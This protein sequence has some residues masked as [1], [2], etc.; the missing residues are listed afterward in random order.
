MKPDQWKRIVEVFHRAAA[1]DRTDRARFLDGACA[2]DAEFRRRVERMLEHDRPTAG[3][4]EHAAAPGASPIDPLLGAMIGPYRVIERISAGGMG[5]VY[6]AR[7]GDD[8]AGP[9]V[10][11]KVV[12]WDMDPAR[13]VRRFE[14]ERGVLASL[15]HPN[16]A[17]L[18]DGGATADGLPYL[19][20][21]HIDGQP[22]DRYCDGRRLAIRQRLAIFAVVCRAV[23][24]AHQRLVVHRDLKP[25]NILVTP[26]GVPKILDFGIAKVLDADGAGPADATVTT[27][28]AL[29]PAYASPEQLRGEPV[30]TAADVYS[31]GVMLHGLVAGD[32]NRGVR[33]DVRNIIMMALREEPSRRYGSA[34][35]FAD[36]I[37]RCLSGFPVA[38]RPDTLRYR[39]GRFIRR[40]PFATA[41]AAAAVLAIIGGALAVGAAARTARRQRDEADGAR[42]TA[43]R[44][45]EYA[46]VEAQSATEL[47]RFVVG[48]FLLRE[49]SD[50]EVKGV[51]ESARHLV[52]E[53]SRVRR[54]F[55]DQP[56]LQANLLDALGHVYLGLNRFDEARRAIGDAARLRSTAFGP[57]SREAALSFNS[58]GE[59]HHARGEYQDA[60]ACFG[61]ALSIGR[62][63]GAHADIAIAANNLGATLRA[64][65]RLDEA[66]ALHREALALRRT[67]LGD[68]DPVVAE[69][70]NN[71]ASV[72]LDRG[73]QAGAEAA[74]AES[75]EVRRRV[76][77][78]DH[79]LSVQ[80]LN[81]LAVTLHR[82]GNLDRAE[83]LYRDAIGLYRAIPDGD[84]SALART[85]SN[86]ARILIARH[87]LD[88]AAAVLEEALDIQRRVLGPEH[89]GVANVLTGLAQVRQLQGDPAAARPLLADGLRLRRAG[90]PPDHPVIAETLANYGAL[91]L[92]LRDLPGAEQALREALAL[93]D[94]GPATWRLGASASDLGDCLLRQER[95]DE[96]EPH[97]RRGHGILAAT[98]GE[99]DDRTRRARERLE[100]LSGRPPA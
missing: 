39:A 75:A 85:L 56:Q 91:L 26:E 79:P 89:L 27:A 77:G 99:Q 8:A 78:E 63:L 38:A 10:A 45:A 96:A 98:V 84:P 58:E 65:G 88:E 87:R 11:V 50:G 2:G 53:E 73:D 22:I 61:K 33:G 42:Q 55:R 17:R 6:R 51:D 100:E 21:E 18:L 70:L 32:G 35:A 54:Q 36:D 31:L 83:P 49:S 72:L 57:E 24:A 28:R 9:L 82:G 4:V 3:D 41:A 1:L 93:L 62:G 5:V 13:I 76:L 15:D 80:S 90:L 14:I 92:E 68:D 43:L 52:R 66:E 23:H 97:L 40:N 12:R 7:R 64:V 95:P 37:E 34:G 71:L 48:A 46:R 94:H 86:Y 16:I 20:M 74:L 59:L 69:S 47:S 19:V 60:A 29:T 25:S 30:T 81:N 44:E 67:R